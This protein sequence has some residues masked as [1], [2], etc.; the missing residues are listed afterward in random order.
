MVKGKSKTGPKENR[1][2]INSNWENAVKKAVRK[3]K[4]KK[5]WPKK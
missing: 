2:K 1:L 3:K 5:G 4:P